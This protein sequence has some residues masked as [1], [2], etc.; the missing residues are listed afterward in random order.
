[1]VKL[2]GINIERG[3][4]KREDQVVVI[5]RTAGGNTQSETSEAEQTAAVEFGVSL[6]ARGFM[7]LTATPEHEA[8]SPTYMSQVARDLLLR[9]E[10]L[11]YIDITEGEL[12]IIRSYSWAIGGGASWK[13][14][15]YDLSLPA[16]SG[17]VRHEGTL[18]DQVIHLVLNAA[19]S[20]PWI[21]VSPLEAAKVSKDLLYR[22]ERNLAE[23]MDGPVSNILVPP[24]GVTL[25]QADRDT[26]AQ[27]LGNAK[28]KP[29]ILN[30]GTS[31]GWRSNQSGQWQRLRMG[32]EPH[33]SEIDLRG[34][35]S[36]DI[37]SALGIP[38]GLYSPSEGSVSREAYRQ[39]L[40]SGI[41]ALANAILWEMRRKLE[42]PSLTFDFSKMAAAD[43]ATHA[44]A[45]G[46]FIDKGVPHKEALQLAGLDY[47]PIPESEET[48][49]EP[50]NPEGD[51][52]TGTGQPNPGPPVAEGGM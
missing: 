6:Y 13:S 45:Y 26:I 16:P 21:G 30:S 8:L 31:G 52:R 2:L 4:K 32:P 47:V 46:T 1:M 37:L 24:A 35:A 10:H 50:G 43:V 11:G 5:N 38:G 3:A 17:N 33:P 44:R 18:P 39:L 9:G 22:I 14:W 34:R 48:D 36:Q 7:S 28:G 42:S 40:A 25:S 20:T 51:P 49:P 29:T 23:E 19:P 12:E 41:Q 27:D 15:R